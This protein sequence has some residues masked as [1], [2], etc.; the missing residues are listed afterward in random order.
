MDRIE[1]LG[2]VAS[3]LTTLAFLPQVLK[4]WKTRSA[5]D[6]SLPTLL[7]LELGVL[8]WTIYGVM[9]ATPSV[10]LGNGITLVLAGFILIVKLRPA[11][12]APELCKMGAIER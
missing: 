7:M 8:L 2:L 9:R 5:D 12:S 4:T 1:S 11:L 3:G 10:W 6:F